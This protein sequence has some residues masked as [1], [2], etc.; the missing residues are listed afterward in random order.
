LPRC[1]FVK[2][3]TEMEVENTACQGVCF[4]TLDGTYRYTDYQE[5]ILSDGTQ[6]ITAIFEDSFCNQVK[7]G[8]IVELAC[9]LTPKWIKEL[10]VDNF[11]SLTI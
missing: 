5:A 10:V 4:D 6:E 1:K 11:A 2:N 3:S 9:V 7:Q 8:D